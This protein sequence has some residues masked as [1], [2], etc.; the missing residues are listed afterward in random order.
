VN[1]HPASNRSNRIASFTFALAILTLSLAAFAR[2][3]SADEIPTPRLVRVSFTPTISL[4][5]LL[6]A[7]LDIVE[8]HGTRD[9]NVLEW[10]GD[11]AILVGIGARAELIDEHPGETLARRSLAERATH[12]WGATTGGTRRAGRASVQS[13][14]PF[15]SGSMAGYWTGDEIKMKLDDLVAG[16]V[17]DVVADKIDTLGYSR[18]GRPIWGLKL[19]KSVTGPDTRPVVFYNALTHARE[20]EGMEAVFHFVDD[21]L[22]K[23]GTDPFATSLLNNRV[24]YIVPL[25]NPDGYQIN[26]NTFTSSGGTT[27]GYW[28]KNARDNDANGIIN[29]QDGVDLNRNFGYKWGLDNVGSSG[30]RTSDIYRG[31]SAF[32]EPETQAQRDIVDLLK[33]RT[34]IS[35]H[36]YSDLMLYPWGYTPAGA[37]DSAAFQ[38]WTDVASIGDSYQTGP[39]PRVLYTV[40]GEFNDWAYGDTLLKPRAFTWTP[41]IGNPNDDFYPPPSRILPL[42]DENLRRCYVV[43]ALAGSFVRIERARISEGTLDIGALAHVEV[44]ARN[45]G[46]AAVGA[47]LQGTLVSLDPG[48]AVLSGP[49]TYPALGSRQSGD[50]VAGATFAIGTADTLTPGRIL[51]LEVDFSA[52]DGSF[53]RD[54]IEVPAGRPT[55]LAAD[56]ATGGLGSWTS[57]GGWGISPGDVYHPAAYFADS[58]AGAY[59]ANANSMLTLNAP[60]DLSSGVHAYVNLGAR[61]DLET[62]YDAAMVEASLD[63][64][65]W[66]QIAGRATAIGVPSTQPV[67][68]PIY[69]GTRHLWAAERLDLSAF[70]GPAGNAVRLRFHLTSD[71]GA[72]FDGFNFDSLRVTV[73]DPAAQPAPL[74][75]GGDDVAA[76]AFAA[77]A[78][79]PALHLAR[80]SFALP[81][82]GEV[83]LEV[84]DLAGRH[85][86]T[87]AS[88]NLAAG[89]YTHGW[90]LSDESGRRV[91]PGIYFAR[92][93]QSGRAITRRLAVLN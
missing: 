68:A 83:K 10:P 52:L 33:P 40:N 60:L 61:W 25:V 65:N 15:G 78:P 84:L 23:Y 59:V 36:T 64:T 77:P 89:R 81:R 37:P 91:S 13:A 39:S 69:D 28:R 30:T 32:S 43:A 50:A 80:F 38:E 4:T 63:G 93:E 70:A 46:L 31:P 72:Q 14:P 66:T 54:T 24:I 90:D 8:V 9:A 56:D 87:L 45:L 86:R 29:T 27:F 18:Q 51:R 58:P 49:V 6:E 42:A 76:L 71:P 20:P 1:L 88:G 21:L 17:N 92:L 82:R 3:A 12:P 73:F 53:S 22:A 57:V 62:G 11:E 85:V 34:G 47:G 79:N 16:D 7:G 41:E 35:F 5:T 44:R 67:G 26:V 2:S 74:A 75:V 48:V 19:G 55:T